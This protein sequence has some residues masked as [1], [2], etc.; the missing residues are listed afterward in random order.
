MVNTNAE[1]DGAIDNKA[2]TTMCEAERE[3]AF[4]TTFHYNLMTFGKATN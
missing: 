3:R 1:G 4:V 2:N